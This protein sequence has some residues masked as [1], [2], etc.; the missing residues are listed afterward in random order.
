MPAFRKLSR[1]SA[2]RR[3]LLRT[4]VTQL[5]EHERIKTTVPKAKEVGRMAE[6]MVTHAKKGT[7]ASRRRA[8]SYVR[9]PAMVQ[10]LFT[11]IAERYSDR[12]GGYT[13]LIRAGFRSNDNAAMAVLE[14][15]DRPEE[16]RPARP[17]PT[18]QAAPSDGDAEGLA[19]DVKD[20]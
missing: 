2:H 20:L 5:I 16:L 17:V 6:K 12:P 3:A 11:D 18:S 14:F 8:G 13:R 15:V 7:L 9:T 19:A 4:M 1:T 10:K